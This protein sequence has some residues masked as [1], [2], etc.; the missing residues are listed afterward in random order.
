MN[1]FFIEIYCP[2]T[3]RTYDFRIPKRIP[4]KDLIETAAEEIRIYESN[5][6]MFKS[7]DNLFLF[8]ENYVPLCPDETAEQ[9]GILSGKF[10]MLL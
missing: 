2:A 6:S 5:E 3:A 1:N 4:I 7:T 8:D 10:L 9:A